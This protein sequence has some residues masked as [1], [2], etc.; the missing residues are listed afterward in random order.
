MR[1]A[2]KVDTNH[3]DLRDLLRAIPGLAVLDTSAMS[4]LGCDLLCRYQDGPPV[5]L[6]IK[7]GAKKPLTD[8]ETAAQ[9]FIP[10][11]AALL[12]TDADT[13][14]ARLHALGYERI[15]GNVPKRLDA[16]RKLKADLGEASQDDLFGDEYE[17][18]QE[19]L[20]SAALETAQGKAG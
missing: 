8:S 1:Y 17:E 12:E 7:S 18:R 20:K 16:Y 11:A 6:E 4:G 5:M 19:E 13:I 9:E 15:P 10:A 3:K 14:K 2:K